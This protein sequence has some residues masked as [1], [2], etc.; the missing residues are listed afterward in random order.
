MLLPLVLFY[1]RLI[2]KLILVGSSFSG[3]G[4]GSTYFGE[5]MPRSCRKINN[6]IFLD[7]E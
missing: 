1:N 3:S 6:N 5:I 7:I 4:R 2:I